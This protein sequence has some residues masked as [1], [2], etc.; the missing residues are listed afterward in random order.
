M[1]LLAEIARAKQIIFLSADGDENK[2]GKQWTQ[3]KK[4]PPNVFDLLSA[5]FDQAT[6]SPSGV[7]Y[8]SQNSMQHLFQQ[9]QRYRK[10]HTEVN[11]YVV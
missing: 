5:W 6:A 4:N 3:D 8:H 9:L 1:E 7:L 10:W 2:T 11:I